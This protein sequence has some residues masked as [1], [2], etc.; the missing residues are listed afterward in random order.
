MND[1]HTYGAYAIA[2]VGALIVGASSMTT[3]PAGVIQTPHR[4]VPPGRAGRGRTVAGAAA[5]PTS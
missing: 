1:K 5:A 3:T 2:V 4:R